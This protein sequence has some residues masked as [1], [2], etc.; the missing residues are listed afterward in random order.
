VI[1]K[2]AKIYSTFGAAPMAPMGASQLWP[3]I[4]LAPSSVHV[5]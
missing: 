4:K 2:N 1:F 3:K 5:V